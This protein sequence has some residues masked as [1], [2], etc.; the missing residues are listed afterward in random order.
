MET[1]SVDGYLGHVLNVIWLFE[2]N[3]IWYL[4]F[5]VDTWLLSIKFQRYFPSGCDSRRAMEWI[6]NPF[7]YIPN[8]ISMPTKEENRVINIANDGGPK[9]VFQNSY[10]PGFWI[11]ANKKYPEI[12]TKAIKTLLPFPTSYLC[13]AGVSAMAVNSTKLR[14]RLDETNTLRVS[15]SAITLCWERL[16]AEKQPQ[17]SHWLSDASGFCILLCVSVLIICVWWT[18][19][20]FLLVLNLN[21]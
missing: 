5:S 11:K 21:A 3:Y 2:R 9:I 12:A 14:S 1:S 8:E 4:A 10:L 15:L 16:I 19:V 17:G 6:H 18:P 13:E 7:A 20:L